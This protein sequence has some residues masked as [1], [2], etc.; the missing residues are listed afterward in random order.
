MNYYLKLFLKLIRDL[1]QYRNIKFNYDRSY[2]SIKDKIKDKNLLKRIKFS[3]YFKYSKKKNLIKRINSIFDFNYFRILYAILIKIPKVYNLLVDY[4]SK[5]TIIEVLSGW[6]LGFRN[7]KLT[8]NRR[9]VLKILHD[10]KNYI[11]GNETLLVNNFKL[12]CYNLKEIGKEI[13]LYCIP[14]IIPFTIMNTFIL[15]QYSYNHDEKITAEEGDII[16]DVGGF[17]GDTALYF[18]NRI[19]DL[20]QVISIE[21]IP[22]NLSILKMNINL[23]PHLSNR[24]K[25]IEG[26]VWNSSDKLLYYTDKGISSKIRLKPS[27]KFINKIKTISID[28]L[29]KRY[30][31]PKIDFIKMDIEGA[32]LNA[33]MGAKEVIKK[34]KPKLAI[35]IYHDIYDFFKIPEFIESLKLNY[36]FYLDH[37]SLMDKE[38][39]LFAKAVD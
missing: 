39:I 36:K 33:L 2:S 26:A 16:L 28:D 5:K 11:D 12:N 15:E 10:I 4:Y 34:F 29:V 20:G 9:K 1:S 22:R 3:F 19:K 24:I 37:F 7:V 35:S 21:F 31:I 23:N 25:I 6:L 38:T 32:E 14:F 30:K 13:R 17:W 8:I 27:K 18:A